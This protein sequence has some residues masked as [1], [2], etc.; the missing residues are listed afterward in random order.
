MLGSFG[1]NHGVCR[2][3]TIALNCFLSLLVVRHGCCLTGANRNWCL[4]REASLGLIEGGDDAGFEIGARLAQNRVVLRCRD[5][6]L[7][8]ARIRRLVMA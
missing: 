7:R 4:V 6:V 1:K 8:A 2:I 5:A 3:N